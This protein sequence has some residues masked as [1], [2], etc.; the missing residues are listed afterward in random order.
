M[1]TITVGGDLTVGR[2][3]YG[4]MQL[5]GP[6]VWGEYSDHAGVALLRQI[7]PLGTPL[8]GY[9][10]LVG[11]YRDKVGLPLM[12][13]GRIADLP[14]ARDALREGYVDLV[15]MVR[16]HIADPHIVRKLEA[17]EE[18]R[19]RTCV[20]ASYCIN[21]IYIGLDSL[22]LHNPATGR[23][24]LIPHIAPPAPEP[25]HVVVGAGPAGL[26]AARVCAERGYSVT[27]L[28]AA[29]RVGGQ[30]QLAA[31]APT[32]TRNCSAS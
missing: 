22:C 10:P 26:E 9:L 23:E 27:L 6:D 21:R 19:I 11:D 29:G 5:T 13:A 2:I 28:E 15:G 7:Q 24:Q 16:A 31:R 17:G 25:K 4:A 12:H 8:G 3:G 18:D 1:D 30:V 14:T 32:G 20:G